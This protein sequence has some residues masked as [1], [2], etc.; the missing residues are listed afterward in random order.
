MSW[1]AT[2]EGK[3]WGGAKGMQTLISTSLEKSI[4]VMRKLFETM[5]PVISEA[6]HMIAD[7]LESG[8][9]VYTFGNGGSAAD[10]QHFACELQGRFLLNRASLP[11]MSLTTNSSSMTA[12]GNDFG[13]DQV[14]ARQLEGCGKSGDVAVA[15]STSG[16]SPNV[17][18]AVGVARR[19]GMHTIGL[20]GRDGGKLRPEVDLCLCVPADVVYR[21]QEGYTA[22]GHVLCLAVEE[23]L[24][25]NE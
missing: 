13:F 9:S 25:G 1:K 14:F 8:G 6:A 3:P 18:Q 20:T 16:N 5:V 24:F 10:A 15:I 2:V 4:V 12:I 22:I 11:V 21:I 23:A 7:C 19:L 17:L